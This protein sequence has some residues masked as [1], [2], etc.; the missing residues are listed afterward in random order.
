VASRARVFGTATAIALVA[1][2]VGQLAGGY[3]TEW[4]GV[5]AAIAVVAIIYLVVVVSFLFTPVLRDMDVTP[6][7][8][9]VA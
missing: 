5:Q 2:P 8:A 9:L 3:L 1:I 4:V 7:D 6:D